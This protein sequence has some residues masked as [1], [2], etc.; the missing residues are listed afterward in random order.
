LTIDDSL[1]ID[2]LV[3]ASFDWGL[4]ALTIVALTNR[5]IADWA[6]RY[7]G[8]GCATARIANARIVSLLNESSIVSHQSP[9]DARESTCCPSA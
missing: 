6:P 4:T 2:D 1:M 7:R 5:L 3:I 8:R 9:M